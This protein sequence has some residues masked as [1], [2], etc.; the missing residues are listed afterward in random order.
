VKT[1]HIFPM[2]KMMVYTNI[3]QNRTQLSLTSL[4]RHHILTQYNYT[5]TFT[6]NI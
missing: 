1:T 4:T 2:N 5:G 6:S 3:E